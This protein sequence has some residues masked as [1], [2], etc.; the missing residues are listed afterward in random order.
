MRDF[1]SFKLDVDRG[2][3]IVSN[4]VRTGK[5]DPTAGAMGVFVCASPRVVGVEKVGEEC[6]KSIIFFLFVFPDFSLNILYSSSIRHTVRCFA[7][8]C[9][10]LLYAGISILCSSYYISVGTLLLGTLK[11]SVHSAKTTYITISTFCTNITCL[12]MLDQ[13]IT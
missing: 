12:S 13:I 3:S 8:F 4:L 10:Y 1:R 7:C 9:D 2:C 11:N 5:P 6:K